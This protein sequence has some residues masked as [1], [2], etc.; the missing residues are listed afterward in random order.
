MSG[1]RA[2]PRHSL[3]RKNVGHR[4]LDTFAH[5]EIFGVGLAAFP[6]IFADAHEKGILGLVLE[7][8]HRHPSYDGDRKTR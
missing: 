8:S 3:G 7:L 5:R 1:L 6:P 4:R 2:R